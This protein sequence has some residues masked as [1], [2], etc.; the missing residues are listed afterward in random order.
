MYVTETRSA[1]VRRRCASLPRCHPGRRRGLCL[2]D[3]V[4]PRHPTGAA[5]LVR[6]ALDVV[7]ESGGRV[8]LD[9]HDTAMRLAVDHTIAAIPRPARRVSTAAAVGIGERVG[10]HTEDQLLVKPAA[11]RLDRQRP[12]RAAGVLRARE[13]RD[14]SGRASQL[15]RRRRGRLRTGTGVHAAAVIK[16]TA[17]GGLARRPR[18][19]G[20]PA[21]LVGRRQQIEVGPMSGESNVVGVE[22]HQL[23]ARP[24]V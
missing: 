5:N 21:S 14:R 20:V 18:L 23:E 15:S 4:W 3:T 1:P 12:L 19:L 9:W 13:P 7:R 24:I 2:C 8:G 22:S 11:A 17:R 6:F 10:K 16:A